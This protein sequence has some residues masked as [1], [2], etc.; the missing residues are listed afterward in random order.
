MDKQ[1]KYQADLVMKL[2]EADHAGIGGRVEQ[3]GSEGLGAG[4]KGGLD[5]GR[6]VWE[7]GETLPPV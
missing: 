1:Q 4:E 6:E 3:E 7:G 5:R 2:D